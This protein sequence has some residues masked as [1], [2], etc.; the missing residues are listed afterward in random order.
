MHI[1]QESPRVLA[2]DMEMWVKYFNNF[3]ELDSH[4]KIKPVPIVMTSVAHW[5][6][7]RKQLYIVLLAG[8]RIS[9]EVRAGTQVLNHPVLSNLPLHCVL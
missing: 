2:F 4:N 8:N 5:S 7:A 3:P 6:Q 1:F 9:H